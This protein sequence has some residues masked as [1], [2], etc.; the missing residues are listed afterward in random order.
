MNAFLWFLTALLTFIPLV[1]YLVYSLRRLE[2]RRKMLLQCIMTL[3]L[4]DAYMRIRHGQSHAKWKLKPPDER[5]T[6]FKEKH[7]NKDFNAETSREDYGWPVTLVTTLSGIGW[8]F[9]LCHVYPAAPG[10]TE[11]V[12]LVPIAFVWGFAGA[13]LASLFKITEEFRQYSLLPDSYYAVAFRLLFA[14]TAAVLASTVLKEPFSPLIAFGIGLL[15]IDKTWDFISEKTA[16][17]LGTALPAREPG[18]GLAVIQ[19]LEDA[20]NRQRLVDVNITSVQALATADPLFVLFQTTFPIRTV[21]DMIDK[22]ILYLYIG[23]KVKDLRERGINGVIELVAL[24]KLIEGKAAYSGERA[25]AGSL[26]FNKVFTL[27]NPQRLI[28]D[29]GDVM[30]QTEDQLKAFIYNMYYDPV[31]RFIYDAWGSDAND[32]PPEHKPSPA[33]TVAGQPITQS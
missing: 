26:G 2:T 30:G 32:A 10:S 29:V 14:S 6:I 3:E 28:K 19:G 33:T 15:P 17:A 21:V 12:T 8:Y 4:E 23:D 7:F 9:A 1:M 22:A 25:P 18:A 16:V 11:V 31:V 20:T 27:E 13:W 5:A 24:A